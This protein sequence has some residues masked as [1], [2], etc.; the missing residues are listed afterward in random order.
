MI[1]TV[2]DFQGVTSVRGLTLQVFGSV[3]ESN[4]SCLVI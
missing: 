1:G 2:S 3:Y 4:D